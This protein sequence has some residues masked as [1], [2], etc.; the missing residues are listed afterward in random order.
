MPPKNDK[1]M[2]WIFSFPEKKQME[3]WHIQKLCTQTGDWPVR[4]VKDWSCVELRSHGGVHLSAS[5]DLLK[6]ARAGAWRG[7]GGTECWVF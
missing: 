7:S 6:L 1:W 3:G 4:L 2:K 5:L